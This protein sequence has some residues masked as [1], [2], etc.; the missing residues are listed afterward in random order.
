MIP[1]IA[2]KNLLLP[3]KSKFHCRC[4][5]PAPSIA[6]LCSSRERPIEPST[7][8]VNSTAVNRETS[9]PTPRVNAKPLTPEVARM[10]RMKAVIS[11][12]TFASMIV[13]MPRV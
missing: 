8:C 9:V 3:M 10:K 6:G 5:L 13:L 1:D 4:R 2:K 11:V 12:T 7:A